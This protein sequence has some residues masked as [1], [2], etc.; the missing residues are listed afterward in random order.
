MKHHNNLHFE[1]LNIQW[2]CRNIKHPHHLHIAHF[3][4]SMSG[5]GGTRSP[6][7]YP[8]R[9]SKFQCFRYHYLIHVEGY[10]SRS[11]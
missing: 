8:G 1:F 5:C 11:I 7:C 9:V 4:W 6:Q 10:L 2:K 3:Y